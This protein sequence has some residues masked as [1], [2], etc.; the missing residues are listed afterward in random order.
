MLSAELL[1]GGRHQAVTFLV[2]TG[3]TSTTINALLLADHVK[4]W[5]AG[6]EETLCNG[7]GGSW[8]AKRHLD[9]ELVVRLPS[10]TD[11]RLSAPAVDLMAPYV[12][13]RGRAS[14]VSGRP[15]RQP[16]RHQ[17]CQTS[18]LLG[19]DFFRANR[20]ALHWNPLGE[21]FIELLE[22]APGQP[23]P[24]AVADGRTDIAS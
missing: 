21:S 6:G 12:D 14:M 4:A 1:L 3:A 13:G 24:E 17:P 5:N 15:G 8:P 22:E 10:E 9:I 2:D 18:N 23:V 7:V 19:R 11:V 20:M 16:V